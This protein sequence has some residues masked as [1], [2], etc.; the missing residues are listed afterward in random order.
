MWSPEPM[1]TGSNLR[2]TTPA[3][4]LLSC[5]TGSWMTQALYVAAELRIADLLDQ[6]CR[7]SAEVASAAGAHAASTHRLMCA[8]VT[9]GV[10]RQAEDQSFT[11]TPMGVLL[12][13]DHPA[14]L[15]HWV[16]WW[17]GHLWPVWG[18]LLYSVQT[19]RSARSLLMGTEGFTHL[20]A[21]SV[22][23]G[24][25]NRAMAELT[26][27]EADQVLR[28]YDFSAC[29]RI[30][31]I[32]GGNGALLTAVLSQYPNASGKVYDLSHAIEA[33]HQRIAEAGLAARCQ[34]EAGDFFSTVPA[35]ADT[36]LLKN[37]IHDWD[38]GDSRRILINCQKVLSK[39]SRLLLIERLLP[40]RPELSAA[41]QM[42]MRSDLTM[43]VALAAQERTLG[44]FTALLADAGLV[45][46]AVHPTD[47]GFGIIEAAA[48]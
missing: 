34:F 40:D 41:Q 39:G 9:V 36:Y 13:S 11:L 19:G 7:T 27:Y 15:R 38:D 1:S 45:V 4:Q 14:S 8:L 3:D 21:D 37:V 32:G 2:E 43:L 10:L 28:A 35:G 33:A 23:A 5:L 25:F 29:T 42:A 44:Q 20:A 17:G 47:A 6:G 12:G 30:V 24:I 16:L 48:A 22:A 31:D 46:V 18:K 26:R